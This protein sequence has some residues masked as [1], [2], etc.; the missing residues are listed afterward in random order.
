M[1]RYAGVGLAG[2]LVGGT[3]IWSLA[4]DPVAEGPAAPEALAQDD[5]LDEPSRPRGA[6]TTLVECRQ[7]LVRKDVEVRAARATAARAVAGRLFEDDEPEP[8]SGPGA[9]RAGAMTASAEGLPAE[10]PAGERGPPPGERQRFREAR[11]KARE[12][13]VSDLGVTAEE[14]RTLGDALCPQREN[15]RSLLL[16]FSEGTLD[17]ASF[18]GA[19]REERVAAAQALRQAL[20]P[21]RYRTLRDVGGIGIMAQSLCSR[22]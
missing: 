5:D 13:L 12:A 11:E 17:A 4:P 7:A 1:L 14:E 18:F 16:D 22:R 19:M 10:G 20:G 15:E 3:A 21:D 2:V 9:A 8:R 6:P